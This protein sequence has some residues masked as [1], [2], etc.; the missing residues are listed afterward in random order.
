MTATPGPEPRTRRYSESSDPEIRDAYRRLHLPQS[1]DTLERRRF[2]QGLLAAGGLAALGAPLLGNV[3]A[4]AGVPL[5]AN[6]R[7]LILLFQSG[8][9]DGLNT[10]IPQDSG[11]Y[12]DARGSLSIASSNTHGIGDGLYLHQNLPR[13]ASRYDN[14]KV[15]IV[16]GVGEPSDD[17]SHF[18]STA[19]W[20]A[21]TSAPA[22]WFTGWAGRYLD[23]IGADELAGVGV[24]ERGVPLLLQRAAG[25]AIALP[26]WTNGLFGSDYQENNRNRATYDALRNI[27]TAALQRGPVAARLAATTAGAID[28][29]SELGDVFDPEI[30]TED[31][32]LRDA[33]VATRLI[34]LDVGARVITMSMNGYDHH[35]DQRPQHDSFLTSVDRAIDHI[36]DNVNPSL[37][38]RVTLMTWS[39]FGRRVESNG[40]GGTDHGTANN[41]F[42]V[43]ETVRGGLYGQQPSLKNLDS[44]GDLRHQVDFRSVYATMIDGWLGG[45]S[46]E[47]LGG[48]YED[49]GIF[50]HKC[51]GEEATIVGTAGRDTLRGTSGRDVIVGLGGAD[52]IHGNGGDDVICA[53]SGGDRVFGGTGNDRIYGGGGNDDLRGDDGNDDI[54]GGGGHDQVRG[55]RGADALRGNKGS[56]QLFGKRTDDTLISGRKDT[57]LRG[58]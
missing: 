30:T 27:N 49:L 44:R 12:H 21:G 4:E 1:P 8:G 24:G 18:V 25:E 51:N 45:D 5:G 53:G 32:L 34:N 23:G 14:G 11:R 46:R 20:M 58:Q 36:F 39:E 40:A 13:L 54:R 3:R 31:P 38:D 17:H 15:A 37:R 7:I 26:S 50:S 19:R 42:V 52:M 6:D 16:Q 48:N 43:G 55:G 33:T 47:I 2:L 57:V 29:A 10:V 41:L 35:A 22:P 28:T 56:D 9:N